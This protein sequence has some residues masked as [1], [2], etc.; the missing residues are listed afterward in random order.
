[1]SDANIRENGRCLGLERLPDRDRSLEAGAHPFQIPALIYPVAEARRDGWYFFQQEIEEVR[2]GRARVRGHGEMIMLGGYSYL[3]LQGHP[4]IELAA[5]RA[6]ERYGTGTHGVRLLAGTL[7]IHTE[8]EA[9]IAELK[10]CEAA[11]VLS[12]GFMTNLTAIGSLVGPG[13]L[14]LS[15]SLNHASIVDGCRLSGAQV[16]KLHHNDMEDLERKLQG[17]GTVRHTLVVADAVFSMDGDIYDLPS[18]SRLCRQHGALLM[19]D[20]AHSL[21]VIGSTGRGIEEHYG[22]GPDSYDLKMGTLSKAVPSNGGYLAA[23]AGI[24][25]LIR[26]QGRGFVYSASLPPAQ[27]AAALKALEL[28]CDEPWRVAALHENIDVFTSALS[29]H[30]L[31]RGGSRTAIVPVICGSDA[32]AFAVAHACQREGIF[33]QAIPAPVVP[34]GTARLRCIVTADHE[35]GDLI[36]C[37]EVIAAACRRHGVT[38]GGAE[39]TV[40]RREG[41]S[42]A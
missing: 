39:P 3:G 28:L 31:D 38:G 35:A 1:M 40:A 19:L 41:R 36:R 30:G 16:V 14:V 21:G 11:V 29:R 2:R 13:D 20:E 42:H 25:E 6:I 32:T 23:G 18:A 17:A 22:L 5:I 15:D 33:V 10:G 7:P 4:G 12:S 34:P 37:A 26:H 27:T 24:I 8:L 9:C